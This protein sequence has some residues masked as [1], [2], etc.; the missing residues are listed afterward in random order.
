MNNSN[1]TYSSLFILSWN[2]NSLKTKINELRSFIS[3]SPQFD[4]LLI[5]KVCN[6]SWGFKNSGYKLYHHTPRANSNFGDTAICIKNHVPHYSI[7]NSPL[8]GVDYTG[9]VLNFPHIKINITSLFK[10]WTIL[11]N[12]LSHIITQNQ[13]AFIA[14]DFN[15]QNRQ[16][17]CRTIS[18]RG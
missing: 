7:Q 17:N 11:V 12:N 15:A 9:I 18:A 5:Q 16:W 4:I 13:Y 3:L 2:C 1:N 8:N 10:I 6:L 14:G